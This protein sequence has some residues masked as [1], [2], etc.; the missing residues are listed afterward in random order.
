MEDQNLIPLIFSSTT[1]NLN[2]FAPK[3]LAHSFNEFGE[4]DEIFHKYPLHLR[5]N[6]YQNKVICSIDFSSILKREEYI[7][8]TN[9]SPFS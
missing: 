1:P 5:F 9:S 7:L 6:Y 4:S 2:A 3:L 8:F